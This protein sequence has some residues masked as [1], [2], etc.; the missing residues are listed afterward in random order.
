MLN[1]AFVAA[2]T[3]EDGACFSW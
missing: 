1:G 3:T 2:I